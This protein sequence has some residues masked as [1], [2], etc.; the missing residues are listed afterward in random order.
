MGKR[1]GA[2][3]ARPESGTG[4]SVSS[5]AGRAPNPTRSAAAHGT[6]TL[7]VSHRFSTVR[8]ADLIGVLEDGGVREWGSHRELM[9]AGGTYA[10]LFELQARAYA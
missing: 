3:H 6:I 9:A 7:L 2:Y 5:T 10:E 4:A 1:G 8:T